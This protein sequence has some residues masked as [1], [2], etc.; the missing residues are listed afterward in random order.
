[1]AQVSVT[2]PPPGGG[3]SAS[4]AFPIAVAP[5]LSVSATTAGFGANVTVTLTAGLGGASD[6]L[7]FAATAAPNTSYLAYLYI[8][9]NVTTSTCYPPRR[10]PHPLHGAGVGHHAAAR[11]R[12]V[13]IAGVPHRGGAGALSELDERGGGGKRDRDADRRARRC[14]GLARVCRDV[15]PEYELP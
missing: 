15:R 2:T 6:W 11:R 9:S 3:T 13:R 4:L 8:R 10:R 7:A 1:T 14:V 12:H 5:V